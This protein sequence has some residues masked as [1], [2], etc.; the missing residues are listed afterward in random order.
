[1][2]K[3]EK[4]KSQEST[5]MHHSLRHISADLLAI[6]LKRDGSILKSF[7]DELPSKDKGS[8]FESLLAELYR[9]NGWLVKR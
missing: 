4:A 8:V 7:L 2:I 9:G 3:T 1:M 5:F 6:L